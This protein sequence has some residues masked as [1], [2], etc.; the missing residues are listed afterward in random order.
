MTS[1]FF[2]APG[3]NVPPLSQAIRGLGSMM[4]FLGLRTSLTF[5]STLQISTLDIASLRIKAHT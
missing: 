3:L 4:G 5:I 2:A 1:P